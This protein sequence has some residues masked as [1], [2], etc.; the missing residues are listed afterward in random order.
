MS[1]DQNTAVKVHPTFSAGIIRLKSGKSY[2]DRT[3]KEFGSS[4]IQDFMQ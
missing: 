4:N 2:A 3:Q 1:I